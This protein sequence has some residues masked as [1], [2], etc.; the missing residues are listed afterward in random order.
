MTIIHG[1]YKHNEWCEPFGAA[2]PI[3]GLLQI[4]ERHSS[5]R[6][7]APYDTQCVCQNKTS[8]TMSIP[9]NHFVTHYNTLGLQIGHVH[10]PEDE[11]GPCV[12]GTQPP[13]PR[14]KLPPYHLP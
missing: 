10:S 3:V 2:A 5:G 12:S 13:R 14:Q 7:A 8:R 11:P 4:E 1:H 6:S 9:I